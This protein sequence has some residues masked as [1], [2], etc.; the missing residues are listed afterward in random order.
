[1][2]ED[3]KRF[4][5]AAEARGDMRAAKLAMVKLR[6]SMQPAQDD[7]PLQT[8]HSEPEPK[9]VE[10]YGI[11]QY[12]RAPVRK[13]EMIRELPE[14]PT[15]GLLAGEDK[16]K[17]ASISP[18]LLATT[19]RQEQVDI[20]TANFPNVAV[21]YDKD[22]QGDVFPILTNRETGA[23]AIVNKP[24]LSGMD[25]LQGLGLAAAF[26]P[27]GRAGSAVGAGAK[28]ALTQ[29]AVEGAQVLQGGDIDPLDIGVAA[30]GGVAGQQLGK[31]LAQVFSGGKAQQ[32]I[33]PKTQ[34]PTKEFNSALKA[35][36]MDAGDLVDDIDSGLL[37]KPTS[38]QSPKQY[39]N[40]IVA[41]KLER[42]EATASMY[43]L[44]LK[45]GKVIK[46]ADADEAIK[47]GFS[48]GQIAGL[49][50]ANR[51]TKAVMRE[52]SRIKRAIQANDRVALDKRPT[53]KVGDEAMKRV[54]VLRGRANGLRKDL[55]KTAKNE[56]RGLDIDKSGI[57]T[58]FDSALDEFQIK[59]G[60]D[61]QLDFADS[62]ISE[63]GSAER[64]V[65]A[66][67]RL[68]KKKGGN[69]DAED[70]HYL[71]RQ[72]DGMIDFQKVEYGLSNV[73]NRIAKDVRSAVND[74]IRDV[75]T[76]YAK[77]NDDLSLAISK[78]NTFDK[79]MGGSIDIFAES[80]ASAVGQDLRG[81]LSNRRTRVKVTDALAGVED[82]AKQLGG[83]FNTDLKQLISFN[84]TLDDRFGATAKGSIQ[85]EMESVMRSG[86]VSA[87]KNFAAKKAM[88]A[89]DELRGISESAAFDVLE[90]MLR[91]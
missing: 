80:A 38:N 32:F 12:P 4:I 88:D 47:Q 14:L 15:S 2:S 6:D 1:M 16:A 84:K 60:D 66:V 63:D 27:A 49:P 28:A 61:G 74:S 43:N 50:Q 54:N 10:T 21:T 42:G 62:L 9:P 3:L 11:A 56:L 76:D 34:L 45:N 68:L 78:L 79:A 89:T 41:D 23:K 37:P 59:L 64:V 19:D 33:D 85:G 75:S 70:A 73:G 83:E 26:T 57:N 72:L 25:V 91:N 29:G 46:N 58:R 71:K 5:K 40:D 31:K 67:S 69:I 48:K 90:K 51:E 36:G 81:L 18:T 53:D 17:T 22:A 30:T 7:A 86:P 39:L 52:M 35:K 55:D 82:A 8:S 13:T 44:Q 87:A 24:G 65:M 20:I 77:I